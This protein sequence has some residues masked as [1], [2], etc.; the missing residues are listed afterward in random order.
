M[1][2]LWPSGFTARRTGSSLRPN[3]SGRIPFNS[4]ALVEHFGPSRMRITANGCVN[5][6]RMASD[7]RVPDRTFLKSWTYIYPLLLETKALWKNMLRCNR[8]PRPNTSSTFF[9]KQNQWPA[10]CGPKRCFMGKK[11]TVQLLS[12][13]K[14]TSPQKNCIIKADE[15]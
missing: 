13:G 11:Q 6:L 1:A 2:A 9:S 5:H 8:C 14:H 12:K 3:D 15:A 4:D 10:R 7:L